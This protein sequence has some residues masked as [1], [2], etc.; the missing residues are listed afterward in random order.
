MDT[1]VPQQHAGER[2]G[3]EGANKEAV[4][5]LATLLT[6]QV[7]QER[8]RNQGVANVRDSGLHPPQRQRYGG[9]D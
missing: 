4:A 1:I 2:E 6:K 7:T 5:Q 3:A 8:F 9:L